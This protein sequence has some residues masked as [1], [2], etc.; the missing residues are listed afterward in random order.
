MYHLILSNFIFKTV[1]TQQQFHQYGIYIVYAGAAV[2]V[3]KAVW[4]GMKWIGTTYYIQ[5]KESQR[6]GVAEGIEKG[7]GVSNPCGHERPI[8]G[9]ISSVPALNGQKVRV[10]SVP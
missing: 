5:L 3:L 2:T 1:D 8:P 7:K 4:E 6:R 10:L 9:E